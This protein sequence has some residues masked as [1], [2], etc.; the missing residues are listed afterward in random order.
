MLRIN[1]FSSADKVKGQGVGS[2]YI[3]LI[4]MLNKHFSTEFDISINKFK[5]SD[6]SHYHTVDPQF[7]ISTFFKKKRGT[8]IGYVHFLPETLEGSLTLFSPFKKVF[9]W[10]LIRFYGRMDQLVVVNPTFIPKLVD[11]GLKEK[12]ITYIPNFVSNKKF[13]EATMDE[14]NNWRKNYHISEEK[15]VILGTGQ[16]QQRKGIDDFV[17]LAI[18]N[19]DVQF[20]W[21]G[22]F[23]FG[24]MTDGYDR[25][26]KI[27]D[28]PPENLLFTGIVDREEIMKLYNLADVF[29]LPS[30]NELF[31][32]S[33]LEAFNCGTPVM[34]RDLDLYHAI[35]DEQY[36]STTN[37]YDMNET[38][39]KIKDNPEILEEYKEKSKKSALYYSEENVAKIWYDYYKRSA[40]EEN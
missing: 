35:I 37:I 18:D 9:D 14:K 36:I 5:Q 11:A 19:P 22:G 21:A 6:I 25:Y 20:I 28:N 26:K 23:S 39:K 29:L 30:Y 24:K 16:I 1:M 27:Y 40:K 4:N 3:E 2:A 32:M 12:R 15:L 7:F 17:Q 33:I 34:L 10:Y 31:P 13:Y 38:I 8:T